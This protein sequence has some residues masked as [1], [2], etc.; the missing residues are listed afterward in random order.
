MK[1]LEYWWSDKNGRKPKYSEENLSQ[2]HLAQHM[3][4]VDWSGLQLGI[5]MGSVL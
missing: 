3:P 1:W 4:H 2:C 5:S